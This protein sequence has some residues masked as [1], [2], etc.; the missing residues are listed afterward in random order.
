MFYV[1]AWPASIG[2]YLICHIS[3]SLPAL[4]HYFMLLMHVA[5]ACITLSARDTSRLVMRLWLICT[6]LARRLLLVYLT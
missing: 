6:V 5:I 4:L 2:S 1:T 3:S